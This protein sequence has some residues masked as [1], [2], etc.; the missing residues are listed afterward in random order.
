MLFK[1]VYYDNRGRGYL[2]ITQKIE[3]KEGELNAK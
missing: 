1:I 3:G 2:M